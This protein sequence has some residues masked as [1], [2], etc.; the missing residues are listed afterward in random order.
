[1]RGPIVAILLAFILAFRATSVFALKKFNF[2]VR[3]STSSWVAAMWELGGSR[4]E[5]DGT[6]LGCFLCR[7]AGGQACVALLATQALFTTRFLACTACDP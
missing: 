6:T 2:Q 1:M 5:V 3:S 7:H 4:V